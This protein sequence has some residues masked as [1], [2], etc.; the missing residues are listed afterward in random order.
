MPGYRCPMGRRLA[1]LLTGLACAVACL[2]PAGVARAAAGF[3]PAETL[4]ASGAADFGVVT[5][6]APNG[7]AIAGW[8]ETVDSTH[9]AIRVATRPP[10]GRWSTPQRLDVSSLSQVRY[11]LSLAIDSAGD[12]VIAWDDEQLG[13]PTVDTAMVA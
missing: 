2:A 7:F 8:V 13:S 11:P 6:M 3:I 12:A 4:P 10:G 9:T 5:A 1:W